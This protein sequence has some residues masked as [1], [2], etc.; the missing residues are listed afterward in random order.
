M[1]KDQ[2]E[3]DCTYCEEGGKLEDSLTRRPGVAHLTC[4]QCGVAHTYDFRAG[5]EPGAHKE[6]VLFGASEAR[7]PARSVFAAMGEAG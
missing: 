4:P 7:A 2:D 1:P 6:I 5:A 3:N